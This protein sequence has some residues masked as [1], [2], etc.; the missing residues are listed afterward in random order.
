MACGLLA[1]ALVAGT[2]CNSAPDPE[3]LE[4]YET[5]LKKKLAMREEIVV[6]LDSIVDE[7]SAD[8]AID[9]VLEVRAHLK[10]NRLEKEA[11]GPMPNEVKRYLW[12]N[13]SKYQADLKK[14]E[15][16]AARRA[17]IVP[18]SAIFFREAPFFIFT[19][20]H[21]RR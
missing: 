12:D 8:D 18:G 2:G 5:L 9:P 10:S 21:R 17:S 20:T 15:D 14:R 7:Y 19:P 6:L 1:L 13:Y 11:L 16:S 3:V 4:P